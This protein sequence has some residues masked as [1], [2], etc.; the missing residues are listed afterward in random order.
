MSTMTRAWRLGEAEIDRRASLCVVGALL[1]GTMLAAC[2]EQE[3]GDGLAF[4]RIRALPSCGGGWGDTPG[5]GG[6]VM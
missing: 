5:V 2:S 4:D 6:G 3:L 1:S